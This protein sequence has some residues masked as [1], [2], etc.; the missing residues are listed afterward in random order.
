MRRKAKRDLLTLTGVIVVLAGIVLINGYTRRDALRE[1]YVKMRT[2]FEEKHRGEGVEVVDWAELH[3]VTG[4]RSTGAGFPESLK[5]KD[6]RLVNICG[7]MSPID[8][9][10]N[11]TEFMLLPV[12]MTCYFCEAP[13][14][15]DIIQVKLS[16]PA[17]MVNEP[18]LIGG[19]LRLHEGPKQMFFYTI[20]EARWNEAVKD[21]ED[22][23][24]KV[25]GEDHR[26]HLQEGFR[27][28][29]EGDEEQLL[30]G[31]TPPEA[32]ADSAAPAA[33]PPAQ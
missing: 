7:F 22:Q 31:Y 6:G 23:T 13:P 19:R 16:K 15:R 32:P 9:F 24:D 26:V 1:Q 33:T 17:S 8:Q 3:S 21:D 14:M 10:K 4:K 25:I 18:V 20:E 12:P 11:V 27:K 30:P 5:K 2:A 29:R 28:M